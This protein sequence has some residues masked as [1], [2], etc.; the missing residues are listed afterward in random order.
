MKKRQKWFNVGLRGIG[1]LVLLVLLTAQMAYA[2]DPVNIQV[3]VLPVGYQG[4]QGVGSGSV[5]VVP[6]GPYNKGDSVTIT[7][8]PNAGSFVCEWGGD[9]PDAFGDAPHINL[10]VIN[11]TLDSDKDLTVLFSREFHPGEGVGDVDLDG[12]PDEWEYKYGLNHKDATGNNGRSGNPSGDDMPGG[13]APGT[14]NQF[15][16][17]AY[18]AVPG[19]LNTDWP[20]RFP[21]TGVRPNDYYIGV[22]PFNNWF[23]CRGFDGWYGVNPLTT[24]NDDPGTDPNLLSTAGD[25]I[26]D[27]WKYYFYGT[28]V[29]VP[30]PPFDGVALDTASF[31]PTVSWAIPVLPIADT[32]MLA[33][34][35]AEMV[36]DPSDDT[37]ADCA[38]LLAEFTAGTDPFHWDTDADDISDGYEIRKELN[39]INPADGVENPSGDFMAYFEDAGVEYRHRQVYDQL[40]YD[41]RTAWG[42]D[43]LGRGTA[44]ELKP[45][46]NTISFNNQEHFLASLYLGFLQGSLT[47]AN[48]DA[49]ALDPKDMDEDDDGIFDGWELYV[50][51]NPKNKDDALANGD[52]D[53][54]NNFQEFSAYDLNLLHGGSW[55]NGSTHF[56]TAWL[57]KVWPT[58]PNVDDTDGDG[59]VDGAE[60][61]YKDLDVLAGE[62][63][64]NGLAALKYAGGVINWND[65]CYIG[66]GLNPTTVD[67]DRDAMPDHWEAVY[68]S[69]EY[70]IADLDDRN[71]M[72]GTHKDADQDYD[73]DG[74]VSYQEYLSTSVH[75]WNYTTWVAG[76]PLGG[77]DPLDF[78]TG[79][80]FDWDW[81]ITENSAD[82]FYV[83]HVNNRYTSTSPRVEDT[84]RDGMDDFWEIYH[85]LNPMYGTLDVHQSMVLGAT[86]LAGIPP[87]FDIRVQ[88]YISGSP[89][90]DPDQD[91]LPNSSESL[92]ANIAAP[93]YYHTSPAPLWVTDTSYQL[94]WVNLYYGLGSLQLYWYYGPST[95]PPPSYMFSFASSEGFDTD[96]D[97]LGDRA[98]LVNTPTSPGS[99]DPLSLEAPPRRR[100]LYLDGDAA[101][102]T[103]GQFLHPYTDLTSFTIEAWVRPTRPAKGEMQVIMERTMAV[104]NGNIMG[105][106]EGNRRNFRLGLDA[107]GVPFVAYNGLG[108]D[109]LYVEAKAPAAFALVAD[110]WVHLAGVYDGA[111]DRLYLFIDGEMRG[112]IA[113]A[114]RP[115]TGWYTGNPAFVFSSPIVLG[116]Q[117][118][119][120]DGWVTGTP[121][122][123]GPLA[124][125]VLT[126][127]DLSNF[128]EGWIDEVRVWNGARTDV[129]IA[130][131][132]MQKMELSDVTASRT[133]AATDGSPELMY[134]Y[135][136]NNLLDPLLEGVVPVGF[137]LLNGRPN[138]G[139]YPHVPWWGTA[140]DQ[141]TAY[142]NYLYVPWIAN[143]AARFPLDPPADSPFNVQIGT[144]VLSDVVTN[145]TTTTN[146]VT[147]DVITS[148]NITTNTTSVVVQLRTYPNT[149]NP[150]NM[151]YYHG[152]SYLR[153]NNPDDLNLAHL[154]FD[155]RDSSLFN[156]LLP[157][158]NARV[159]ADVDLWDGAGTGLQPFDSNE[160]GIPD[161]WYLENGF[162]PRSASIASDD[163]DGD[164][165][166]NYW[167]YRIGSDPFNT[168]SLDWR[169]SDADFDS[170]GDTISNI[171]EVQTWG[172]DPDNQ[173]TDDDGDFDNVEIMQNTSALY[174]RSPLVPR[175][176][177]MTGAPVTVPEPRHMTDGVMGPQRFQDLDQWYVCAMVRP[178]S[179]QTGSLVRRNV[180]SGEIHFE[181]GLNNNVPFV[182]F[183]NILGATYTASGTAPL[184]I[185]RFSSLIAEFNPSNHVLSLMVDDCVVGAVNVASSCITGEGETVIGDG[186]A[187]RI[188]DV[189]IGR[190]L[191]GGGSTAP[192][193]VLMI[194]VSGSMAAE[195]RMEEAKAAALTAID[196]MPS[197]SAMAI[198]TFDH[199][200]QQVQDFTSDRE[201]LKA[202]V[203]GL[204]PIGATSYSA[205]VTQMIGLIT[206]RESAGG[207]VGILISD[208][209]PN[210]GVPTDADL[211]QVVLLNGKINTVGFGSSILAGSTDDLER[212]ALLT[213]GTFFPAPSGD[214]LAEILSTL[215]TEEGAEDFCFYPFD[216]NGAMAEDYTQLLDWDY[217]LQGVTFDGTIFST[218]ITPFNYSFVDSDEELPQWWINWFLPDSDETAAIDDPDGDGLNNLNE[219]RISFLNQSLGNP[220]AMSPVLVDSDGNGTEDGD[221]D[222]DGD[223]LISKDEQATHDSRVNRQDTDDDELDDN[224]ELAGATDPSYS[225]IPYVARALRFGASAGVG[226]VLVEDRVRGVDT[227][228]LSA[229]EWT[230]ECFVQPEA[231]PVGD[232]PL[233]QRTLRCS[234][235]INYEL[236]IRTDTAGQTVPYVRF[237]HFNDNNVAELT[238]GEALPI[239]EWSHLAG[240]LSDGMLSLFVDGQV[241]RSMN[242]GY[243]PAQGPGDTYFGGN[244]FVG[245]LKD[246]RIWK[247][248]R[249]NIDIQDFSQRSIL[250]GTSAADAGLLRVIGDE[251][252]LREVAAPGTARD[253]LREWTLETWVRTTDTDG[254]I[255]TRVNTGSDVTLTDDCNYYLGMENGKLVGKFTIQYRVVTTSTNGTT[256]VGDVEVNT[257]VNTLVSALPINDGEW[258]HVAYTRDAEEA[259]LY[260]DG[261]LAG[262]QD[263]F[264]I[265]LSVATT[266]SD[267]GV[268]ILDGPVEVGRGLIGEIDE[269]RIWNRALTPAEIKE[270]MEQNLYGNE[271]GLITYFSFDFQEGVHAEDR[272]SVR[273]PDVEYGTY[274]PGAYH[275]RTTDQ[276]PIKNFYPLRV[277]AFTSLLGYYS[278]DDGGDTLE[279]LLYQNNWDY[280]GRLSGDVA[281]DTLAVT[282]R[283]F[284]NDSDGDG[285][286][287][288]WETLYGLDP[289]SDRGAD[290][291]Y[292]D[293]DRDG[294]TNIAEY[295]ADTDPTNWDTDG[296]GYSDYDSND[297][298]L[299]FGEYYMDGDQIPDAWEILYP[300]VL[301]PLV[302]D[303][304]S[305]P[306]GDGWNNLSEYLGTGIALNY[307][308]NTTGTGT[309]T[310]TTVEVTE[311]SVAPTRPDSSVSYPVPEVNFTFLGTPDVVLGSDYTLNDLD[312]VVPSTPALI[313]WAYSDLAMRSP[314]AKT[315]IPINGPFE[316]GR[317]A[318]V[319]RWATGHLRE[320][321]TTFMAFID[322][323]MDG[324]WNEG[325]WL[326][327]SENNTEKVSW[328][329]LNVRIG[330]TDKP[331]GYVRFSWE[332]DMESIADALSQV[333][334]TT[335]I[336]SMKHLGS[337][338]QPV[339]YSA[340]R[341]L[342]SMSRP[343][344]TE[345]DLKLAGLDP[346]YGSYQW[347]V[348]TADGTVFVT[349]TNAIN[350]SSNTVDFI[351]SI[352]YPDSMTLAHAYNRLKLIVPRHA[353]EMSIRIM[354]GSA[355]VWAATSAVPDGVIYDDIYGRGEAEFHMP[356]AGWGSFT[357][358]NYTL[359]IQAMNPRITQTNT[360]FSIFSVNLQEAPVGAGTIKGAL[361]YFGRASGNRVVEAFV[362]E[363]FDQTSV[364]RTR[365]AA[366][367]SYTLLG[368]RAG[369]YAVRGYVDVDGN[370]RLDPGEPWGFVKS[371]ASSGD[372]LTSKTGSAKGSNG[373]QLP[374]ALEY[375]VKTIPVSAQGSALNQD[376][377]V[378]D[379]LAYQL[380]NADSDFDG[381]ADD[382]ELALGTNPVRW[383]TDYDGI[384]D[385][386]EVM[387]YG[388]DPLD[389]DSD[390][391]TM[392]DGWELSKGLNPG[393][394]SDA[395]G[396]V[397]G[398]G[399]PN[400][401]EYQN[402]TNPN[403]ADTDGDGMNDGYEVANGL[404]PLVD[405][406]G[407]D[408]DGDGILNGQERLDNTD[409][410]DSDTDDDGLSDGEEQALHTNP[411]VADTDGDGC[412]DGD[413]VDAGTYPLY[414]SDYPTGKRAQTRILSITTAGAD[415]T[416]VYTATGLTGIPVTL[417]FQQNDTP[418]HDGNWFNTGVERTI[419][420]EGTYTN[421]I[422]NANADG[423][424]NIRIR[425]R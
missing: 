372:S 389:P 203:N 323:N 236:G 361:R 53:G 97:M 340:T 329:S 204:V 404:D 396:D 80:P 136:F 330:L 391:D 200:V 273:N 300:S 303:A 190:D 103:R 79:V 25:G 399:L 406:S 70:D 39:P 235:L 234:G 320:G 67:T 88:P 98:E 346:L 302:N 265:P 423:V 58:D 54:L 221:E 199:E 398:D 162:D 315:I 102:R 14:M 163:P 348:G 174:S 267:E 420:V 16:S 167:E 289:N 218:A 195:N 176:L 81:N 46:E 114:E 177:V 29:N 370:G 327:Y 155:T 64:A 259:V 1:G 44:R 286:P 117:E 352:D 354:R 215:V 193:Y 230:I 367:G 160:D 95:E 232:Q 15:A 18:P 246:V 369:S 243:D 222:H 336:V 319:N 21:A 385:Y 363:G 257:T 333:N 229:E 152:K 148:T 30:T 291:A 224:Q 298:F 416:V 116:A 386:D 168:Y 37:D 360:P 51:L 140:A 328:G 189:F 32:T 157:L 337:A 400:D 214:D 220:Q 3:T 239:G 74:L 301:S 275:E 121:I 165:L 129:Q 8:T 258:H 108:Y 240:R 13:W 421:T 290:G 345:M 394:A 65:S 316:N 407:D 284:M 411:R 181:L 244:G 424:L 47:C 172:T 219:W 198:V 306:D 358:G 50:G 184:P 211:A 307:T 256:T 63:T 159:D 125:T 375:S 179:G 31:D 364:A 62:D 85:G 410:Q 408:A 166:S 415:A 297:G 343:F 59:I 245:R 106:P 134:L 226:E 387:I 146:T 308:T 111:A 23:Q 161:W 36:V 45:Q 178:G 187:G 77:Y 96:T 409:P 115:A 318:T 317:T 342:E 158:R 11:M 212:I 144:N 109:P 6:A 384:S 110:E 249:R 334:G 251:G 175:S 314:D 366:D 180:E 105:F 305:D 147:G 52:D 350:Y 213:G 192:D 209:L 425:C 223:T 48:F 35:G 253:Q 89:F 171:D 123:V 216:D 20:Y 91:G 390:G 278:A 194:D 83:P 344:V 205:P 100:A 228:H 261:E 335:Y 210:S 254:A 55:P 38:D 379:T 82:F 138:D 347:A 397:D 150:Y 135:N 241:V 207:Y 120:P 418:A 196:A 383:D 401:Q 202:L 133:A 73:D 338:S 296:D 237:N 250:F 66:C 43:Y 132:R 68:R 380:I 93:E 164:G 60:G 86:V 331:A 310:V 312:L 225:M 359:L 104:P 419:T 149:A 2:Q 22:I 173:D 260:V 295:L 283:P 356:L 128:F 405:D 76:L 151:G 84:D 197:G 143:V 248:G 413:E 280:A 4:L 262:I 71:G 393:S 378:Y 19:G 27:G 377:V 311:L 388:T 75:H 292:G 124:G 42:A 255:L 362:G 268:R 353:A 61:G 272:A 270:M 112:S 131:S 119:N 145:I 325:E 247:I 208:G 368:L 206:G 242:T 49:F 309:S 281:F 264:L 122:W 313:V 324:M 263:G 274:I 5:A 69:T 299:T 56:D 154:V 288:W 351:S 271:S 153:E 26:S 72:D 137:D 422:P 332:N 382:V 231:S 326:G 381:L 339:I 403:D 414:A 392:A 24:I 349:G 141:S 191:L 227:E 238:T 92:Q 282:N 279:N 365:A 9:V 78:F 322:D 294:L 374:Y 90:S 101:A 201:I 293:G 169:V 113:S 341:H 357:N 142:N 7:A 170:D 276:A 186:I 94:S 99:T 285:L 57:N 321:P 130:A 10:E 355:T 182:R 107:N 185:D 17:G 118:N 12:L 371:Q 266:I 41:P 40:A 33:V 402:R 233:V 269:T 252:H 139:S 183:E 188:D 87:T 412:S 376:M 127:P 277:Y 34:F 156:D 217:A 304:F 126:Q 28:L 373:S 395:D 287:D 417:Q